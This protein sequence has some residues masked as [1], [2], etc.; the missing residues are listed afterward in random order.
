[1]RNPLAAACAVVLCVAA[2][3]PAFA[4]T[5]GLV[6]GN[7]LLNG[8]PRAGIQVV[9]K[10]DG[11]L[12][13]TTTDASGNFVFPRVPFG[14]YTI[15][16]H[17]RGVP[18]AARQ[19]DVA[20]DSVLSIDLLLG[21]L[22]VIAQT[23]VSASAGA[24]GTPVSVN[25]IGH[26]ELA[27]LPTNGN[28]DQV[29][30]TVPGIIPFSYNEP[31]ANGFH[32][33]AYEIDGAPIPLATSS[34]FAQLIDPRN[35]DSV[36]II[37]GAFPA[38][39]GGSRM[40]A[41]IN[42]VTNRANALK[43]AFSGSLSGGT[44]NYG[45]SLASLSARSRLGKTSVF[46]NANAQRTLR[47]LDTPTF[48]PHN[49]ASSQSDQFLR[50]VTTFDERQSL[51]FD[52]SNQ[53]SQFQIPINTNPND[54]TDPQYALPG[55]NDVQIEND[56]FANLNFTSIS[57]DG[58]GLFQV[59][60]WYRYTRVRYLG[61][62][63]KDVRAVQPDPITGVPTN[64]IGL[65]QD[66]HAA[67]AGLNVSDFRATAH[68]AVKIGIDLSRETFGSHQEFAQLGQPNV[69]TA[70]SHP[71]FQLGAYAQDKWS[72]SRYVTV[73][74]GLRYDHSTG[75]TG[76]SQLSPRIGVNIAPDAKNVV[77]VYY[78]R[79]YAAPQ[80]EDVRQACVALNGCPAV[81][82]YNLKPERDAYFEMG[83]AHAFGRRLKGYANLFE[84]TAVNVLDTTQFLNTPLFA[85]YNNAIGR[86]EGLD[87]RLQD[88][89][90]GGNSWF[91]SGTISHSEAAGISGSTFLFGPNP[92]PPGPITPADFQPEDHDETVA[93]NG[94]Y[95][96]RFGLDR[97][98]F[99]TLQAVYG[100]G[101]PVQFQNGPARL[102]THLT[103]DVS[104][105]KRAGQGA[106]GRNSLGF[107]LQI[108]NLLNHQ[109]VIK[110]ANGFNTTQIATGRQI[111]FQV[112]APF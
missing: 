110:I 58:N 81:P 52:F 66:L 33:I 82:V 5:A 106:G 3:A 10:G 29:I 102:P 41:L 68:H 95:T 112:T 63:A 11:T 86:D 103:F 4:T 91:L 88:E 1:M 38:E 12:L 111:L 64:L 13:R 70:V 85:V 45:Q 46:F 104:L 83:L 16:A 107:D 49:D 72:P 47:G 51:A 8:A 44:G 21:E 37:T 75:F 31:I 30:E 97:S 74:Y 78:G 61:D 23:S 62:L 34:N 28:L 42:I 53:L 76:G 101:F 84:R 26:Q 92:N 25:T 20:S 18:D 57:K 6:R 98:L 108:Q 71:G 43:R 36:E 79:L 73:N 32:G 65:R 9:V 56:R 55:T 96:H 2:T 27:A 94:A 67:Y 19:I 48:A 60:P 24:S 39:Y 54:P 22:R 7:V 59:I 89:L 35:V 87:L 93:A 14:H 80:L 50:S 77:H 15:V 99:T 90:A 109:Y 40:G 17:A 105:G 69:F 100:T